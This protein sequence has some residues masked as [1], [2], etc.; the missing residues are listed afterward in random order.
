MCLLLV[1][2]FS[3]KW[4]AICAYQMSETRHIIDESINV[5]Q[6]CHTDGS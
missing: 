5:N 2:I 4:N 1:S 3:I 6:I